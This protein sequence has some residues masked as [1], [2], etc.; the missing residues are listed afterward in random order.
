[1]KKLTR[2]LYWGIMQQMHQKLDTILLLDGIAIFLIVFYHELDPVST[3]KPY[4]VVP[5]LTL[6]TFSSGYKLMINH[7]NQ[8]EQ[9]VF[10][11]KYYI[12]R[13]FRLY[14]PYIGYT[15]LSAF[16]FLLVSYVAVNCFHYNYPGLTIFTT[17]NNM[18]IL[19]ILNFFLGI[20][21]I[22]YHLWYLVALIVMTGICF[23]ILYFLNTKWLFFSFIPFC[24][25]ALL[26]KFGII[27]I[28]FFLGSFTFSKVFIYLPFFIL[29]C[30]W[31]YNQQPYQTSNWVNITRFSFLGF[32]L[33]L[34]VPQ[35][36]LQK[37]I[38][39]NSILIYFICFLFPIFLLSIFDCVKKIKLLYPFFLFCGTFSFQ[40]YL[41]HEPLILPIISR[42]IINILKIDYIFMPLLISILSIYS[43][44]IVYKIVKK[45]HLNF[46]LE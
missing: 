33:I 35:I 6:F 37:P 43:C 23:C 16:P 21:P 38:D 39:E 1:M 11:I 36:I 24:L 14:K 2:I 32:F 41:F 10:L 30:Y 44:V 29:G 26:I 34:I 22:A 4:L 9:R 45:V 27:Q 46:L 5:G 42:V 20:N 7:S 13:F 25:I 31:A 28:E 12:K 3:L 17:I 15:L 40:I 19:S 18:N 8:L